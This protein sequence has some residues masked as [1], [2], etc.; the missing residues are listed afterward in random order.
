MCKKGFFIAGALIFLNLACICKAEE[1]H[2]EMF[3]QNH[4]GLTEKLTDSGIEVTLGIT[5]IYQANV[6]GG[7][8][9]HNRRGRHAGSYDLEITADMQKLLGME[10]GSL[11][12]HTEGLWSRSAG[13]DGASVGSA[14][15]VNGDAGARRS[16]DITELWYEQSMLEGALLLRIGK[17]D[18]TGGFECRGCPVSFDGSAFANDETAQFLNS[19]LVNNPTIPFPDYALGIA[20]YYNPIEWWYVSMG[21]VD[22]QNDARETGFRTSFHKEDYF[23]YILETGITPRL[24]S[25]KGPLQGAYR[26]GVWYDPQPKR[27]ADG[28]K[29]YRDDVGFYLSLDQTLAKENSEPGDTQGLGAFFRYGYAGSRRNNI[30]NFFSAGFQYE[31]LF[32]GRDE[33]VLGIGYAH[34]T[35]SDS[36]RTTY[37]EDYESVLELYYN[38]PLA[39]WLN[40]SPNVQYVTNPG[41]SK[42]AK[43]AVVFGLRM[44]MIF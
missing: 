30:T 24:A 32:E 35:F 20:A 42:T 36:A 12:I 4:R 26:I 34:G 15:G 17:M 18:L 3:K 5:S 14:F 10:G 1:E 33:D 9:T 40:V 22:A 13:I 16:M 21:V 43:D 44:Q 8:S 19:A 29:N 41:G 37:P 38:A 6:K 7:T 25:A 23:F 11:Y 28:I 2:K 39:G 27:N 31:G